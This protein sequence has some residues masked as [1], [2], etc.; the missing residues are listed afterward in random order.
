[1]ED[2]NIVFFTRDLVNKQSTQQDF[3]FELC[4]IMNENALLMILYEYHENMVSMLKEGDSCRLSLT[5]SIF[6]ILIKFS[7]MYD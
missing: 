6:V 7:L 4:N 2:N 1:M 3:L 5:E